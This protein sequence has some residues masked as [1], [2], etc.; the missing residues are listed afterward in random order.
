MVLKTIINVLVFVLAFGSIASAQNQLIVPGKSVG[1]VSIGMTRVQVTRLLGE[2]S[3]SLSVEHNSESYAEDVWCRKQQDRSYFFTV[4]T[5]R[6]NVVQIEVSD[7]R[8]K[9]AKSFS[10]ADGFSKFRRLYPQTQISEYLFDSRAYDRHLP[11]YGGLWGD[12][13]CIDEVKNGLAVT[14]RSQCDKVDYELPQLSPDS[15]IVHKPGT[16]ALP[17]NAGT[18]AV[19]VPRQADDYLDEMRA[20]F[21]GGVYRPHSAEQILIMQKK[22]QGKDK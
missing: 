18:W 4:I 2:P 22:A 21:A 3:Q 9:T 10:L 5:R 15:I 8:F 17:I 7:P 20:W 12:G 6:G 1:G 13:Y 16:H 14:L 19:S 11:G